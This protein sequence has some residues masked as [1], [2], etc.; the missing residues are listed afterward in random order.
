[1][2]ELIFNSSGAGSLA[3][4]KQSGDNLSSNVRIITDSEGNEIIAEIPSIPYDGPTI[5]G[6]TSDIACL[7]LMADVGD[8]SNLF[9]LSSRQELLHDISA[10]H[11][12]DTNWIDE[13]SADAAATINRLSNAAKAGE[14]IRIWWSECADE[15]CGFYWAMTLLEDA[16]GLVTAIIIPNA[17]HRTNGYE[18][19]RGTGNLHPN[20]FSSL[21]ELEREINAQERAFY[22][23]HWRRLAQENTPLRAVINGIPFSVSEDFYDDILRQAFPQSDTFTVAEALGSVLTA[24]PTGV[25]DWWYAKRIRHMIDAS[26]LKVVQDAESFYNIKISLR[27]P[28]RT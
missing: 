6:S 24:V 17:I 16:K 10:I 5:E 28:R 19:I 22:A 1:M 4:A 18:I 14:H 3:Q 26:E 2:I 15:T 11:N 9:D 27:S 25:G 13:D 23:D 12:I 20:E 21:L 7:W 8:I